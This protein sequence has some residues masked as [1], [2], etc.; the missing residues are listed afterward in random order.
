VAVALPNGTISVNA[1]PWAEVLLDGKAI[2]ETPI[3]NL[4]V[5]IGPHEL[6][7]RNPRYTEQRRSVVVTVG[8]PVRLG[9]DLRQ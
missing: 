2:G 8:T 3:A 6:V 9:V 7:L 1:V 4:S 5:P